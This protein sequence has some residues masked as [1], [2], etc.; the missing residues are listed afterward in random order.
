M[1]Y[2]RGRKTFKWSLKGYLFFVQSV[3]DTTQL[4]REWTSQIRSV[5]RR[6]FA[7]LEPISFLDDGCWASQSRSGKKTRLSRRALGA[8]A[9]LLPSYGIL[10]DILRLPGHLGLVNDSLTVRGLFDHGLMYAWS[11]IPDHAMGRF[12]CFRRLPS[13]TNIE[14]LIPI[15]M[16]PWLSI[17]TCTVGFLGSYRF[18]RLPVTTHIPRSS[19]F[20][21]NFYILLHRTP[22][23]LLHLRAPVFNSASR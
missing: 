12:T 6:V 19:W 14:M 10:P 1:D 23:S 7:A 5:T 8:G 16:H 15:G 22:R 13:H 4:S 18:P 20:F 17:V 3:Q 2:L 9:C 11:L 21:S